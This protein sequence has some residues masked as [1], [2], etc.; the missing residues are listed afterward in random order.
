MRIAPIPN[1]PGY[2]ASEDGKV[3]SNR[4]GEMKEIKQRIRRNY[5]VVTIFVRVN[6][7]KERHRK[8][9]HRLVL[10]A[11]E[12]LP[13]TPF[14]QGRHLN[15]ISLDNRAVNLAWGTRKQNA[16]DAIKHGTLGL[17]MKSRRRKL[18]EQQVIEIK[19]RCKSGEPKGVIA[20]DYDIH[21]GYI[22]HLMD[23]RCWSHIN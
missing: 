13:T 9:V 8:D 7:A 4:S 5:W 17:G 15:G 1:N 11:F 6:G 10:M 19:R 18:S 23:G 20:T 16:E 14:D 21:P 22:P 12:G 3:F 2:F